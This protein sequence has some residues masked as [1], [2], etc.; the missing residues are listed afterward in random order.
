MTHAERSKVAILHDGHVAFWYDTEELVKVRAG[1]A[2]IQVEHAELPHTGG[3]PT[4]LELIRCYHCGNAFDWPRA[5]DEACDVMKNA[6]HLM[7]HAKTARCM[8]GHQ[9]GDH[10]E[11][12]YGRLSGR[13]LAKF[14][15]GHCGCRWFCQS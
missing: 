5:I 9:R 14:G 3:H 2:S 11:M 7:L 1:T 4:S 15:E 8:C 12:D 10:E 6:G 13:C